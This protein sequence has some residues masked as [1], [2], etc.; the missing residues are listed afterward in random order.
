MDVIYLDNNATTAIAPEV[1][2]AMQPYLTKFYGNPS[3]MYSFGGEVGKKIASAREEIAALFGALPEEILITSCGTE[4]DNSA[5]FTATELQPEK[6]HL[7]VSSVEHPAILNCARFYES[8]GYHVT[9]IPVDDEGRLDLDLYAQALTPDTALV[10]IMFANNETGTLFP[11]DTLARMAKDKGI[12]FHTDAVQAAGKIPIDTKSLPVDMLS[13]SGHKLHAPK[14]IGGLYI[15]K[16]LLFRPLIRGGHQERGRRAGT[17]NTASIV[18]LGAA[19]RLAQESVR[20]EDNVRILR[21]RLE[22]TLLER[23]PNS[24]VNGDR[25]HRLPNTSNISFKNVEGEAILLMLDRYGICA[26][27]GSACTSGSLEP[28]HVLGAMHVP[29]SFAHGS[30]RFSLSRYT[31]DEEI[32]KVLETLPGIIETLRKLSPFK[33]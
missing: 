3:S 18:A 10:S 4:S 22:Q 32:T 15:R 11:I 23:I 2:E 31:K 27:S 25:A 13:F 9:K 33:S 26:S 29:Q 20:A 14:G 12:L 6:K 17:E 16:G 5:F 7:V 19:C 8:K 24:R 21:D 1:Y 30:V 28:S